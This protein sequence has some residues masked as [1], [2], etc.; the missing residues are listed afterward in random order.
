MGSHFY[1]WT[2]QKDALKIP[3]KSVFDYGPILANG[4]K[5]YDLVSTSFH[6]NYGHKNL[7]LN[8]AIQKQLNQ[9][10]NVTPKASHPLKDKVSE[11]L[12]KLLE[13]DEGK[14]FY[15]LSGSES[16]ENALKM[17]RQIRQAPIILARKNCYHGAT[18]GAISATGDWRNTENLTVDDWAK[19][20]P[21]HLED[22]DGSQT[23]Q[24]IQSI[25]PDKIAALILETV[26]GANGVYIPSVS[27][28]K[29]IRN[30]TTQYGI[31]L[32]LDEVICGL[33]RTQKPFGFHH[34]Q[35]TP[36]FVCMAKGLTGG[37]IPLGAVW[38]SK[39]IANYYETRILAC[40]LTNYAHPL[41]LACLN[42]ILDMVQEQDFQDNLNLL[43]KTLKTNLETLKKDPS[44]KE[45]RIIGL[46][47][48]IE[49]HEFDWATLPRFLDQGLYVYLKSPNIFVAPSFN[50]PPDLLDQ[51]L[52]E[53][54]ALV[55]NKGKT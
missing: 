16:V 45:I 28:M 27:W 53:L 43:C 2:A 35:L 40:G 26:P 36:D 19:R 7:R 13:L 49:L 10:V 3:V 29:K 11:K 54:S 46:L 37:H 17:A 23:E 14:I 21:D 55:C 39:E 48:A 12:V 5:I 34:Y 44:V 18:L 9:F 6:M 31:F 1:T 38:A 20:I 51:K 32:I 42:E 47:A 52:K 24:L 8:Q 41:G 30:I 50:Y 4:K 33:Y 22:P 15:T 25:G